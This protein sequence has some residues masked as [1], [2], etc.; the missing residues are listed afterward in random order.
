MRM[1]SLL[2]AM[3]IHRYRPFEIQGDMAIMPVDLLVDGDGV[4]NE[5][6]YGSDEGDHLPFEQIK[7]FANGRLG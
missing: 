7:R 4:I 5:V 6:Y 3:F 2:K 1:P